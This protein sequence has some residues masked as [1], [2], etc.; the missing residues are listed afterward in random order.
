[1][2]TQ[3]FELSLAPLPLATGLSGPGPDALACCDES[4]CEAG[5]CGGMCCAGAI[6]LAEAPG[7]DQTAMQGRTQVRGWD[8]C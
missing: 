6:G 3:P 2:T 7:H 5:C 8:C 4:C 1:M